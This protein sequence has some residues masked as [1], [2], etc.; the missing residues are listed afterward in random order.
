[1]SEVGSG[2]Q[3]AGKKPEV[4]PVVSPDATPTNDD[5]MEGVVPT[6][7]VDNHVTL[8]RAAKIAPP[9]KFGGDPARFEEFVSKVRIYI[10]HNMDSFDEESDKATF[11]I[12]YLEGKAFDFISTYL[13]DY[14]TVPKSRQLPDTQLIFGNVNSLFRVMREVYGDSNAQEEAIMTLQRLHM[15]GTYPEYVTTFL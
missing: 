9:P 14:T 6:V 15:T 2:S 8:N 11:V 4:T 3:A 13:D 7:S 5:A 10:D 12:S 1:M